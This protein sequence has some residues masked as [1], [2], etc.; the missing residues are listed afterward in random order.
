MLSYHAIGRVQCGQREPGNT[1][2]CSR[3]IR[4]MQTFKKLPMQL[5]SANHASQISDGD[6]VNGSIS[7]PFTLNAQRLAQVRGASLPPALGA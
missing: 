2:D 7:L 5:P 3:G 1:M 6:P 4:T